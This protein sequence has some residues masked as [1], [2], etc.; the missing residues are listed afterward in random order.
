MPCQNRANNPITA[1]TSSPL[2]MDQ[3][4]LAIKTSII[5]ADKTHPK[6]RVIAVCEEIRQKL[7]ANHKMIKL[8]RIL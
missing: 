2:A 5:I 1:L 3:V 8:I 6:E 4:Q 7:L